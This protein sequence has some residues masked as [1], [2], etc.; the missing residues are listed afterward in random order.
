[1][2]PSMKTSC[3]ALA[4]ISSL[5]LA[6]PLLAA[7]PAA[8]AGKSAMDQMNTLDTNGDRKLSAT[9]ASA[10][11]ITAKDFAEADTNKDGE[12]D[13]AEFSK[14]MSQGHD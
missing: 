4:L 11:G 8:D 12:L 7:E 2:K 6:P 13:A 9:E 10:G 1:M 14:W 5:A 3:A